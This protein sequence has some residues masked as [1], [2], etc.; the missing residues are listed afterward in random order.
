[1][2]YHREKSILLIDSIDLLT[3]TSGAFEMSLPLGAR[4][5]VYPMETVSFDRSEGLEYALDELTMKQG[6]R[7][8]TSNRV[9]ADPV[10][11]TPRAPGDAAYAV[12]LSNNLLDTMLDMMMGETT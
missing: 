4:F 12:V 3:V 6:G 9:T 2:K 5:S 8:G 11:I 10:R 7:I 1:M